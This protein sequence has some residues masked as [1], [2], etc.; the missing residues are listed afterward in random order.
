MIE[1]LLALPEKE[2]EELSQAVP[3]TFTMDKTAPRMASVSATGAPEA[4]PGRIAVTLRMGSAEAALLLCGQHLR[5]AVLNFAH[6]YN[7]GGGFEHAGG[8]QEE[9]LFRKTS[10]FLSLWPHRRVDDGPGVLARGMWIGD[11]DAALPRQEAFYPHAECGGIFSPVVRILRQAA[12]GALCGSQE[13]RSAPCISVLTVAAEDCG[14]ETFT[15]KL[16][17]EKVRTL[18]H[19]AAVSGQNVLVLGA[20]G[21]GY[22]RNPPEEVADAFSSLL[23]GEFAS[24]FSVVVFAVPDRAGANYEAFA[25]RFPV[26]TVEELVSILSTT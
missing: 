6:G 25:K 1:F 9:D 13:V 26:N 10:L 2:R 23:S 16:L 20:F 24:A 4:A 12:S 3:F 19:M 22:F 14:R 21:C 15:P 17:Q 11:F 7:C 5:P 8:S 18:L